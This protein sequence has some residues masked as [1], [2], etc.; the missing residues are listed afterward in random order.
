[1]WCGN[2]KWQVFNSTTLRLIWNYYWFKNSSHLHPFDFDA[3]RSGGIIQIGLKVTKKGGT[4]W[5]YISTLST[6]MPQAVVASSKTTCNNEETSNGQKSGLDA[7]NMIWRPLC[8]SNLS[9]LHGSWDAFAVTENLVQIFCT[10]NISQGGL[11]QQ[12][13]GVVSILYVSHWHCCIGHS[14]I[15]NCIDGNRHWIFGQNL[16]GR[17]KKII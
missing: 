17:A 8:S 9:Y 2:E 10:Q 6:L 11:R 12:P 5:T 13:G 15:N 14:V 16:M 3:P 7:V 1:M 4:K